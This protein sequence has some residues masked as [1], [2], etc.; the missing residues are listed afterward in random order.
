MGIHIS[1]YNWSLFMNQIACIYSLNSFTAS[2]SLKSITFRVNNRSDTWH[3][4]QYIW[5]QKKRHTN[6]HF[7]H[8]P[9]SISK[10]ISIVFLYNCAVNISPWISKQKMLHKILMR[11]LK[12]IMSTSNDTQ[13]IFH[14]IFSLFSIMAESWH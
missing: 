13:S 10:I 3:C 14:N 2:S 9:Q 7:S 5:K 8:K 4:T 12:I 1:F 11:S 6:F